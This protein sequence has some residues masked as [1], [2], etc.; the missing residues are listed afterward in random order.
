[1]DVRDSINFDDLQNSLRNNPEPYY[2]AYLKS[3]VTG[4]YD[5][6][7]CYWSVDR[8]FE[9]EN[10]LDAPHVASSGPF[11]SGVPEAYTAY[12][13][14]SEAKQMIRLSSPEMGRKLVKELTERG[15]TGI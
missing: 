10:N 9:V 12:L 5:V 3:G 1:M 13:N 14:T 7:G 11:L 2:E 15:S 8:Q 4:V 6:G